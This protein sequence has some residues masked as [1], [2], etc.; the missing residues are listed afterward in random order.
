MISKVEV[1]DIVIARAGQDTPARYRI[2]SNVKRNETDRRFY[3]AD[4]L[5]FLG[6]DGSNGLW[7]YEDEIIAKEAKHDF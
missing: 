7:I 3:L 5:E 2:T 4:N 1:G 6:T